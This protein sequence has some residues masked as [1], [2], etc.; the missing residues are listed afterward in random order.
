MR[1]RGMRLILL[2]VLA[3]SFSLAVGCQTSR[4]P[5]SVESSRVCPECKTETRTFVFEGLTYEKHVCPTC[6]TEAGDEFPEDAAFSETVHYCS[7][8][9]AVVEPCTLCRSQR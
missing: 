9:D 5:A 1:M 6:R 3:A 2:L 4:G 8:C 7:K